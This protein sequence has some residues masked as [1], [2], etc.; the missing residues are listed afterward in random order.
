MFLSYNTYRQK[1]DHWLPGNESGK[2]VV[3]KGHKN[4]FEGD[5]SY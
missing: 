1:T 4:T 5:I 2:K 3:T